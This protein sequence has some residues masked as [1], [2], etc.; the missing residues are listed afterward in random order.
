MARCAEGVWTIQDALQSLCKVKQGRSVG[1]N[2]TK[3]VQ[4]EDRNFDGRRNPFESLQNVGKPEKGGLLRDTLHTVCDAFGQPVKLPLTT[5]NV[6]DIVDT[7]ETTV[8]ATM[9]NGLTV[10][11]KPDIIND[12][13]IYD[14]K[15]LGKPMCFSGIMRSPWDTISRQVS[16]AC[17]QINRRKER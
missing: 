6:S 14:L 1:E 3:I 2:S 17:C 11:C 16:R 5:G 13:G 4:G 15:T 8:Q 12:S 9:R 7:I 10:K